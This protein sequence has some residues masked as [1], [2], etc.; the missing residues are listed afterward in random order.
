MTA[1]GVARSDFSHPLA[2]LEMEQVKA[3]LID[4]S[5]IMMTGGA[6]ALATPCRDCEDR[7]TDGKM[8]KAAEHDRI[9]SRDT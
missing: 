9:A 3:M 8:R 4:G 7:D 1:A 2:S 5:A 6:I